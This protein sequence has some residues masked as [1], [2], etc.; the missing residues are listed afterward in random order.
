MGVLFFFFFFFFS[1]IHKMAF[2]FKDFGKDASDLVSKDIPTNEQLKVNTA[3]RNVN[4]TFVGKTKGNKAEGSVEPK[5][6]FNDYGIT[7]EGVLSSTGDYSIKSSLSDKP[8]KGLKLSGNYTNGS[9]NKN[10]E[11]SVEYKYDNKASVSGKFTFPTVEGEDV[12]INESVTFHKDEWAFGLGVDSKFNTENYAFA[13]DKFSGGVQYSNYGCTTTF[14]AEHK[15]EN[16]TGK[17]SYF[18]NCGK[19]SVGTTISHN[20]GT[21][22]SCASLAAL[23]KADD[24]SSKKFSFSSC[25]KVGLSYKKNLDD[26][27]SLIVGCEANTVSKEYGVGLN[28]TIDM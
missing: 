22:E 1:F 25:G 4:L 2:F 23:F 21:G 19:S 17:L 8:A 10:F 27:T 3:V 15:D 13:F 11:G 12:T 20:H 6:T 14:M 28:M 18:R 9:K 7:V 24:G 5:Y 26:S 16:F